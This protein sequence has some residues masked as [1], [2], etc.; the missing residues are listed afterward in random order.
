MDAPEPQALVTRTATE[1][2]RLRATL[3]VAESLTGGLIG[4]RLTQ[5]SGAS[6]YFRGA[7]VCYATEVKERVLGVSPHL[8]ATRGAVDPMVAQALALGVRQVL[9]AGYGLAVTGVAGPDPQDGV[10]PGTVYVAVC[11]PEGEVS[12]VTVAARGNRED[13]REQAVHAALEL[14]VT[15]L[16]RA[17]AAA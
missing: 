3:A 16:E 11:D 8:L 12:S 7:V 1:M 10:A 17:P 5:R 13:V 14:L 9:T 4:A 15:V 2:Q 6:A